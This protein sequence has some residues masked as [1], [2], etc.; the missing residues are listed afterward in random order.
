MTKL[1]DIVG[2]QSVKD[3]FRSLRAKIT[4][5]EERRRAGLPAEGASALHMV[6]S[7]NPGTGK[8]TVARLMGEL[9][10]AL[11]LLPGGHLVEVTR[12]D[13][14]GEHVGETGPKTRRVVESAVGGVLFVDEAYTLVSD[15]KDTFGREALETIM[16]CMEDMRDEL[17]VVIA[18]YPGQM[19][20]LMARNPGLRSRFPISVPFPD[21][22]GEELT[23]IAQRMLKDR[24]QVLSA[25]ALRSMEAVCQRQAMSKDV[26]SGNARFVRNLLESAAM[27]QAERLCALPERSREQLVTLEACDLG[28]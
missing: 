12:S 23:E 10:R 8:T 16:K 13:L 25:P 15:A 19:D 2:V 7:G 28:V 6:F 26:Q 21:Y 27:R 1:D 17:V 22:S 24:Q 5:G 11:R 18:G 4:I 3:L 9:F 20:E 14:V